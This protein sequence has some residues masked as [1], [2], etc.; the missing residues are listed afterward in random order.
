MEE[1]KLNN[2]V[3]RQVV[4]ILREFLDDP[5]F[6]LKLRPEFE[7]KLRKSIINSFKKSR[8]DQWIRK[9]FEK[10]QYFMKSNILLD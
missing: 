3:R 7:A 8:E 4:E 10:V 9:N 2:L 1:K 5:D 6:G